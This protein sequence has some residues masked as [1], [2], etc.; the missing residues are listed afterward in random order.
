MAAK[1]SNHSSDKEPYADVTMFIRNW[2]VY[3]PEVARTTSGLKQKAESISDA[4]LAA[5]DKM[6]CLKCGN[7]NHLN[8]MCFVKSKRPYRPGPRGR[9][10][11]AAYDRRDDRKASGFRG[12]RERR[13]S[14]DPHGRDRFYRG[15]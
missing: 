11:D 14:R 1:A 5:Q 8:S 6:K 7:T 4:L 9:E 3:A 15:R 10:E 2:G 13:N 12:E